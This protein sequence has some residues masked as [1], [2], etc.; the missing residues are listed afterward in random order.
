[1]GAREYD[2]GAVKETPNLCK[3][4]VD[5]DPS[6]RH[7]SSNTFEHVAQKM[8]YTDELWPAEP[9]SRETLY[10]NGQGCGRMSLGGTLEDL[11]GLK[12][13]NFMVQ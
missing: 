2:K 10:R 11:Q 6:G 3:E 4:S 5:P 1:M 13:N 12:K 9:V 8:A 7:D